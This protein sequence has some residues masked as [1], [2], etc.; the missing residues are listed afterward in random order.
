MKVILL[1]VRDPRAGSPG[2]IIATWVVN[3]DFKLDPVAI[4]HAAARGY[5]LDEKV[6]N[7]PTRP[8]DFKA[9]VKEE[10]DAWEAD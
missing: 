1:R 9:A 5:G 2:G 10:L 7:P 4:T 8:T 3:D 6:A